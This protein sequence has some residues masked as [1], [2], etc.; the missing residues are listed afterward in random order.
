MRFRIVATG[1]ALCILSQPTFASTGVE[2]MTALQKWKARE[3]AK[4]SGAST[5]G[6]STGDET[7]KV[8]RK[9]V[10]SRWEASVLPEE[11]TRRQEEKQRRIQAEIAAARPVGTGQIKSILA[12]QKGGGMF[13]DNGD[14]LGHAETRSKLPDVHEIEDIDARKAALT[15]G[16]GAMLAKK[17]PHS[18]DDPAARMQHPTADDERPPMT[19]DFLAQR[20]ALGAALLGQKKP[21]KR[22][23]LDD[24]GKAQ[25]VKDFCSSIPDGFEAIGAEMNKLVSALEANGWSITPRH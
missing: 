25:L 10:Q 22:T 23:T 1:G 9:K 6:E 17:P 16:L 20:A 15:K 11:E 2:E 18:G 4:L 14:A 5:S 7:H 12:A 8:P 19:S 24:S 21:L 3:A 13:L